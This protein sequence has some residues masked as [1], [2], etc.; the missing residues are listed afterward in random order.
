MTDLLAALEEW[1]TRENPRGIPARTAAFIAGFQA[2][3]SANRNALDLMRS[4][5]I[6]PTIPDGIRVLMRESLNRK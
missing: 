6:N 3:E 5:S 4:L 1:R 2:G